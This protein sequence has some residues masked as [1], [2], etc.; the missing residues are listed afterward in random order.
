MHSVTARDNIPVSADAPTWLHY[1]DRDHARVTPLMQTDVCGMYRCEVLSETYQVEIE[2]NRHLFFLYDRHAVSTGSTWI[3]GRRVAGPRRLDV[4]LDYLPPLHALSCKGGAGGKVSYFIFAVDA[5]EMGFVNSASSMLK[6]AMNVTGDVLLKL[7]RHIVDTA[8]NRHKWPYFHDHMAV[9]LLSEMLRL[10]STEDNASGKRFS[11]A[12]HRRLT[13]HIDENLNSSITLKDLAGVVG[14][15]VYHF[16]RTFKH[17][18]G[19]PPCKYITE[20]RIEKAKRLMRRGNM[21]LLDIAIEVGFQS[22]TQLSRSFRRVTGQS[23]RCY[24]MSVDE[25][26]QT[27]HIETQPSQFS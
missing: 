10:Q 16:S 9:A 15:S 6:P 27:T 18:F 3:D 26:A 17:H 12:Q 24:L 2:S 11:S 13:H 14:L 20:R 1:Q 21:R 19:V 4:G 22:N 8:T 25:V 5:R 7:M 23:P